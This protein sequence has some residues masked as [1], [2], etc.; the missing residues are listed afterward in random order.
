MTTKEKQIWKHH[1]EQ[2][3]KGNS[4]F[5]GEKRDEQ[6]I[7]WSI[8]EAV[9]LEFEGRLSPIHQFH[10]FVSGTWWTVEHYFLTTLLNLWL[11]L[12]NFDN[13]PVTDPRTS[14]N[15]QAKRSVVNSFCPLQK[16][17]KSPYLGSL[18]QRMLL[19]NKILNSW[20]WHN[21]TAEVLVAS[22]LTGHW[23]NQPCGFELSPI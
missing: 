17:N 11:T 1:K 7:Q 4:R 19:W 5:F 2:N 20:F 21:H 9:L 6:N 3:N 13:R 8:L 12:T 18:T 23:F 15:V 10:K 14:L 22:M 16:S